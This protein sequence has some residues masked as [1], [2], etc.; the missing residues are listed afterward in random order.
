[1]TML[2]VGKRRAVTEAMPAARSWDRR[3]RRRALREDLRLPRRARSRLV[4]HLGLEGGRRRPMERR[5]SLPLQ[6]RHRRPQK[7]RASKTQS[8][9]S[10][11]RS[12]EASSAGERRRQ[13]RRQVASNSR[14]RR[15]PRA[16]TPRLRP[17]SRSR[18]WKKRKKS[19][20]R[21]ARPFKRRES[22]QSAPLPMANSTRE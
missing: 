1:M 4:A 12:S 7:A 9:P 13:L 14:R 17:P 2:E 3:S 6:D 18:R 11:L 22:L 21:C 8:E 20:A 19:V 15:S 16:S 10:S 5:P